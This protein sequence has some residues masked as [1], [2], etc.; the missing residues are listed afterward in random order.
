M[1]NQ[2]PT[3]FQNLT[4]LNL[5]RPHDSPLFRVSGSMEEFSN[6]ITLMMVGKNGD[7]PGSDNNEFMGQFSS[8]STR[9][10]YFYEVSFFL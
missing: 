3:L 7:T 8:M 4:W 9:F 5:F 6:L 1:S 2:L 10:G